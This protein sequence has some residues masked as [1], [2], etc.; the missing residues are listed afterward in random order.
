MLYE[1]LT[2]RNA[3]EKA[4]M[5]E[6]SLY[7]A[8]TKPHVKAYYNAGLEVLR[9]SARARNIHALEE[10]RD[11][12]ENK[13]ARVAAV[14]ALEQIDDAAPASGGA[15]LSPGLVIVIQ[16]GPQ[17][18]SNQPQNGDNA[19]IVQGSVTNGD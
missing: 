19:L 9:T 5:V 6:H 17:Q 15:N 1:G 12:P 11:Q 8:F 10:V 3:A 14:K 7:V 13:M 4:G 18:I 2:R 16:N